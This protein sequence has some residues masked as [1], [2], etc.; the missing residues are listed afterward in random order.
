M[1]AII[2]TLLLEQHAV[3]AQDEAPKSEQNI[4]ITPIRALISSGAP[5]NLVWVHATVIN[6]DEEDTPIIEDTTGKIL[7]FLPTDELLALKIPLQSEIYVLGK[8]DISPIHPSKN[9]L[10]AE[11]VIFAEKKTKEPS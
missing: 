9:E 2:A 6:T 3:V 8:V 11:R 4:F 7:L 5:K 1:Y 10:Y